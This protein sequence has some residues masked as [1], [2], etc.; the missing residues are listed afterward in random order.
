[1]N[2]VQH[3][4]VAAPFQ[5]RTA[6]DPRS[7]SMLRPP[8]KI[9]ANFKL[10]QNDRRPIA[11]RSSQ[12]H[13]ADSH[14]R[15]PAPRALSICN[16][17][18]A[19][20]ATAAKKAACNLQSFYF[21]TSPRRRRFPSHPRAGSA[22]IVVL[23]LIVMLS[24]A[25]YSF[26]GRMIDENEVSEYG[27]RKAEALAC[28]ESGIE[29]A[30]TLLGQ[31]EDPEQ[32]LSL[33]HNP[34]QFAGVLVATGS[35]AENRGRFTFVAPLESDTGGTRV[36]SGL[37][38]ESAKRNLNAISTFGLEEEQ[39]AAMLMNLPGMTEEIAD[40]ILDWIDSDD[41]PRSFGAESDTYQSR[42]PPY[43]ARNAPLESLDELLLVQGVTPQLLFGEDANHNG[44]LDPN[45]NDGDASLPF[46][47]ADGRLN[48]GWA[49]FLTVSSRESNLRADGTDKID[50]NQALLTD[51]YDQLA[52]DLD[53]TQA[54]FITAYRLNGPSNPPPTTSGSSGGSSGS[55]TGGSS[56]GGTGGS[57]SGRSGGS[58]SGTGS[59]GSSS[60]GRT[61]G[62]S[63]GSQSTGNQ[64][65]DQAL[66]Q[67]ASGMAA[68]IGGANGQPVTRGGL[69]ISAGPKQDITSLFE[70]VDAEVKVSLDKQPAQTLKSPWQTGS[71]LNESLRTLFDVVTTSTSSTIEG[72]I[73]VNEARREVLLGIPEMT[74]QTVDAILSKQLVSQDGTPMTDTLIQRS[75]PGWM[76]IEGVADVPTMTTLDKYVTTGGDVFQ[77][78]VLGHFDGRG[79]VVRIEAVIDRGEIPP[80]VVSRRD[81][82]PLGPGYRPESLVPPGT[83]T[84]VSGTR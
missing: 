28:A 79:P 64:Q 60:G 45:E 8:L 63:S 70:L 2:R 23:V 3:H 34:S 54:L 14:A 52:E 5:N 62:S 30:A 31:E 36:R 42:T 71:G 65:T 77:M 9:I 84:S 40:A 39:E 49:A 53:E 82:T 48:P 24:L 19:G 32:P 11:S 15:Q 66:R 4:H 35:V 75:N 41:E 38:D 47:D 16:L 26:S 37:I 10:F 25:A 69:D 67:A 83:G 7:N 17:Q 29:Y 18:F 76:L 72:R 58:S 1:M 43:A 59:G 33:Y 68:A 81:L 44:L 57:S 51:L 20:A 6:H 21:F 74:E 22:L 78:Q 50:A 12:V 56:G 61:G 13:S 27:L 73:N 80:R 46:D 55:G